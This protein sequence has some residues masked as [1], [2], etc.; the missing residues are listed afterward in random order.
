MSESI[1]TADLAQDWLEALS[2]GSCDE[3]A[4]LRAMQELTRKDP[5]SGWDLLSLLDQYYRRG[6]IKPETF[7]A[8]KLNL[9]GQLLGTADAEISDP[10]A[11]AGASLAGAGLTTPV[12]TAKAHAAAR[13]PIPSAAARTPIPSAAAARTPI[14]SAAAVRAPAPSAAAVRAPAPSAAAKISMGIAAAAAQGARSGPTV[15]D[16]LRGRYLIKGIVGRGGMSTV[17][18]AI[19]QYRLDLPNAGQRLAIKVLHSTVTERPELLMELRREF[20]HLQSLSHPNI[21]RVYEYD[22]DGDIEFFTMEYLSGLPLSRVLSARHLVPLDRP[23]ALTIMSGMGA[24]LAHAHGRGIVHGDLNPGNIFITDTGEVRVLDFGASQIVRR[25]PWISDFEFLDQTPVA[26]P[27]FA[28]CEVLEGECAEVCDDMYAFGCI[29]YLLLAGKHPFGEHTAIQARTLRLRPRRPAGLEQPQWR[30]LRAALSFDRN[31]RPP[32]V[33]EWLKHFDLGRGAVR[34]P[35]LAALLKVNPKR[36]TRLL[37]PALAACTLALLAAAGW[38][39]ATDDGTAARTVS[40]LITEFHTAFTGADDPQPPA[41]AAQAQSDS[42]AP[43]THAMP[44]PARV[45]RAAEGG[46]STAPLPSRRASEP[47]A[48]RSDIEPG[49]ESIEVPAGEP[50]AVVVI[51]RSGS[52]RGNAS[53]SWW[54]EA[55][56]ARPGQDFEPVV[57][58]E[59]HLA[60]GKNAVSLFVPV[61]TDSTR[62]RPKTF[63]VVVS[64][65]SRDAPLGVRHQVMVTILPSRLP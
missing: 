19:D 33:E 23:D 5:D 16:L 59:E 45:A 51:H 26:T 39:L 54:T 56:T 61:V 18:E 20:Q 43:P 65:R 35:V 60:D 58:R 28:S 52:L 40:T 37:R 1:A 11:L 2:S 30:A 14:P 13:T 15:G 55:G 24:A 17:F 4:F 64:T 21:V 9:E 36:R 27:R 50:A 31:R 38:W 25:G 63:Y 46:N 49:S 44:P 22:R 32:A 3:D 53:F 47:P 7:H 10:D 34:L 42:P 6:K 8:L 48:P 12:I 41:N 57:R 62:R 29:V